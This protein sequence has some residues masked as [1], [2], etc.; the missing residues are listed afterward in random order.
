MKFK[1][2][3]I[4]IFICVSGLLFA[5][6]QSNKKK[7]QQEQA[8]RDSLQQARRQDS[9]NRVQQQ[10]QDSLAQAR[11]E[12]QAKERKRKKQNQISFSKN[13]PFTVQTA[14][15]RSRIKAQ[16]RAKLWK[17]RGFDH[18]YVTKAGTK[19]NGDVWFRVQLGRVDSLDT[20]KKL[21]QKVQKK[22]QAKTWVAPAGSAMAD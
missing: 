3:Y 21:K 10:R 16:K 15:W 6:G 1:F 18:A 11:Q 20:A 22:Y 19:E 5:C 7:Q 8:R 9:L 13:G 17:K 12:K 14:A 4:G 2:K